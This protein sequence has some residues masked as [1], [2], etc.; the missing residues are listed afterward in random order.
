VNIWGEASANLVGNTRRAGLVAVPILIV[1]VLGP[2]GVVAAAAGAHAFRSEVDDRGG[3][4]VLLT[5]SAQEAPVAAHRLRVASTDISRTMRASIATRSVTSFERMTAPDISSGVADTV[6]ATFELQADMFIVDEHF[7]RATHVSLA[8]GRPLRQQDFEIG[9]SVAVIGAALAGDYG[10]SLA[11]TGPVAV[12]VGA[13]DVVVVGVAEPSRRYPAL[14]RSLIIP[15]TA[16]ALAA[17]DE[18]GRTEAS[19]SSFLILLDSSISR[20]DADVA[21]ASAVIA[22]A[23]PDRISVQV[24]YERNVQTD[25]RSGLT[26]LVTA[27]RVLVAA[28][29]VGAGVAALQLQNSSARLRRAEFGTRLSIGLSPRQLGSMLLAEA[30]LISLSAGATAVPLLVVVALLVNGSVADVLITCAVTV[31]TAAALALL[32]ALRT[33]RRTSA[34]EP[35]A[36]LQQR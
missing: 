4:Q 21:A 25:Y 23:K 2:I 22:V 1:A 5:V 14:D 6:V 31:T 27:V 10:V 17:Q 20:L 30:A 11:D 16:R 18:R 7:L 12:R 24:E 36:L 15:R 35:H 19:E 34:S 33:S 3:A 9:S 26:S 8:Q 32:L 13:Q 29:Y 28:G